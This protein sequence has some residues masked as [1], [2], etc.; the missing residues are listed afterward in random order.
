MNIL[1][2]PITK[3]ASFALV[4]LDEKGFGKGFGTSTNSFS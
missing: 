3:K 1:N 2:L 4:F